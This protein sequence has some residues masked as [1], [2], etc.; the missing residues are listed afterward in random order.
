MATRHRNTTAGFTL[1]EML[2][3]IAIIGVL[4]ALLLGSVYMVREAARRTE[5][6][7][8]LKQLGIAV[9]SH[10]SAF[11]RYPSN[12]WG[13]LWIG[14]PDRGTGKEQ[15]GGWIYNILPYIE[16]KAL[17]VQGRGLPPDEKGQELAKLTQTPLP[18][19]LCPSRATPLLSPAEEKWK[20]RNA[21]WVPMVAKSDYAING[22]DYYTESS[23]FEGP[24]PLE[25][26][27]SGNSNWADAPKLS[28]VSFQRS[29]IQPG[30]ILDGESQTYLIG[31]KNV[32]RSQYYGCGDEG[33]NESLYIGSA[34]DITRWVADPPRRDADEYSDAD[35]LCFGSPHVQGCHFVFCDGAVRTISFAIDPE[36]HRRLGNR[37]DRLP[38]D[39][40]LY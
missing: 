10:V 30:A 27:D 7:N 6:R 8:H 11:G 3:V 4:V 24:N 15:P 19:L 13:H 1:I 29:E 22:G 38:I 31:E 35:S 16:H 18:L 37:H 33:Y 20:P 28:G 9:A 36:T 25:D 40:S 32:C 2:V 34:I 21:P 12:G 26:G 39:P 5:C 23:V 14:D 17:R